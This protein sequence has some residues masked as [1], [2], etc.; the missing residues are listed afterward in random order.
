L[1]RK[2]VDG[3]HKNQ[4]L[5][6]KKPRTNNDYA[7]NQLARAVP[8]QLVVGS[9]VKPGGANNSQQ[10]GKPQTTKKND[11]PFFLMNKYQLLGRDKLAMTRDSYDVE[12]CY[13]LEKLGNYLSTL[14]EFAV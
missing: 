4:V 11:D 3:V 12:R 8:G 9:S 1:E 5:P 2:Q 10:V 14:E 13:S 6:S 7:Q